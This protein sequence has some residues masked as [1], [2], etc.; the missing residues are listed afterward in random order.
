M[1]GFCPPCHRLFAHAG[2][3][4][5]LRQRLPGNHPPEG[6]ERL[7]GA[8]ASHAWFSVYVPHQ[9]WVD[10]DPTNAKIPDEQHITAAWGR[11]YADVAPLKGVIFGGGDKN[12]LEVSVDV[13]RI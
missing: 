8:D 5:A 9:G 10:F 13:E 4:G 3:C 7:V 2:T 12:K 11:D 1:P 6:K